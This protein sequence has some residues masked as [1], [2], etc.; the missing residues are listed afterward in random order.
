M[1]LVPDEIF[2]ARRN[3][4]VL[5]RRK[6]RSLKGVLQ[7]NTLMGTDIQ[8]RSNYNIRLSNSYIL[9]RNRTLGLK[10]WLAIFAFRFWTLYL[11]IEIISHPITCSF[12]RRIHHKKC[13]CL[14]KTVNQL[15]PTNNR[16]HGERYNDR[17]YFGVS[18][19]IRWL[20]TYTSPLKISTWRSRYSTYPCRTD[21]NWH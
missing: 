3:R 6:T 5:R 10:L 12:S 9:I 7:K 1:K 4:Q 16:V 19:E 8:K 18:D 14:R 21:R 11:W 13:P 2:R 15:H 17:D 20:R